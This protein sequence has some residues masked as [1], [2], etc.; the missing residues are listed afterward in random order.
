MTIVNAMLAFVVLIVILQLWLLTA[1]M[2]AFLGG[3]TA[4][5]V[6]A[7][8][9]QP[10]LSRPQR[11]AAPVPVRPGQVTGSA[12]RTPLGRQ[13]RRQQS[14]DLFPGYFALVMATGIVSI[15]AHAL[16]MPR[17]AWALLV[18]NI[19][20]Y[21]VLTV[22]FVIRLL[23]YFRARARRPEQPRARPGVL[24]GG[25]RDLRARKR[26][27]DSDGPRRARPTRCG[28]PASCSGWS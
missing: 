26:D 20:A 14:R 8:V 12:G 7:A 2:N 1:T 28:S 22:L 4:T 11:R 24:H 13:A 18:I 23:M 16:Q 10:R 19:C 21:A 9:R 25:R 5:V 17:I 27:R 3:D 6:P 15:A